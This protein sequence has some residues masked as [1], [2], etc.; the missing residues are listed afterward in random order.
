MLAFRFWKKSGLSAPRLAESSDSLFCK[1]RSER[2]P[3]MKANVHEFVH[4]VRL[5]VFKT[6]FL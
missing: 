6:A 3:G 4:G 1:S 5:A 2:R